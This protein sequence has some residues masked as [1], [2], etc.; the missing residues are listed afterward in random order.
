MELLAYLVI[1]LCLLAPT[2]AG[3]NYKKL[4][5]LV[6][7]DVVTFSHHAVEVETFDPYLFLDLR[8]QQL[9]AACP[10]GIDKCHCLY[11]PGTFENGSS[12]FYD[13]NPVGAIVT[14]IACNP[15]I[16]T[17]SDGKEIDT[18]P[19]ELKAVMT[20]CKE[21]DGEEMEKCLC[22]NNKIVPYP[23]DMSTFFFDCR[24][25]RVII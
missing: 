18:M 23:F 17:C 22:H 25:K 15:D 16:C 1:P 9:R 19:A 20:R 3:N 4:H 13:E 2:I 8:T 12:L 14:Y 6:R 7:V 10:E 11:K 5:L 24:A 21:E